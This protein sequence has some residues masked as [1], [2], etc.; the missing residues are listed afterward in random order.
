MARVSGLLLVIAALFAPLKA[1]PQNL[2]GIIRHVSTGP[3][4]SQTSV[5]DQTAN[6]TACSGCVSYTTTNVLNDTITDVT[7]LATSVPTFH[8]PANQSGKWYWEIKILAKPTS[9]IRLGIVPGAN[10]SYIGNTGTIP[11]ALSTT[12]SFAGGVGTPTAQSGLTFT[13]GAVMGIYTNLATG[14]TWWTLDNITFFGLGGTSTNTAS[15][16]IAGTGGWT[17]TF[18]N[19]LR[20]PGI[21]FIAVSQSAQILGGSNLVRTPLSGY[22]GIP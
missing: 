10:P 4:P 21:S 11:F 3:A 8:F 9:E 18:D 20:Y 16:V 22:T 15:D 19:R 1:S 12:G 6:N 13:A 5:W 17:Q 7:A 2:L 14:Q